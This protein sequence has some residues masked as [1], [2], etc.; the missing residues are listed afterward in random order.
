MITAAAGGTVA[1]NSAEYLVRIISW[2]KYSTVITY[3]H[4]V[5]ATYLSVGR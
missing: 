1:P 2:N 4:L 3:R 5:P